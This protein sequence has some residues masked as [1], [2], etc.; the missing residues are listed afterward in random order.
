MAKNQVPD[1]KRPSL[2]REVISA[3]TILYAL[4][5]AAMLATHY[6]QPVGQET[7]TSSM[8]PVHDGYSAS[9]RGAETGQPLTLVAAYDRLARHGYDQ[10]RDMRIDD[11]V[12]EGSAIRD[13]KPVRFAIDARNG[14]ITSLPVAAE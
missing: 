6:L 9:G 10:P 7:V 1:T 5:C 3:V 12:I 13:G 8:S 4:I 11:F 2:E 14:A